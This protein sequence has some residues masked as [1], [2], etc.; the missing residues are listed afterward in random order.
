MRDL[1]LSAVIGALLLLVFKHPVIGAYLWAW[2]S[3]MN[4]H[5][6]TYG[7]AFNLP[8]ALA[9]AVVTLIALLYARERRPL[10]MNGI[11]IVQIVLLLWMSLTSLFAVADAASV[12]ERWIFVVKIQVML[13]ATWML[14]T[15]AKKLRVLIWVVTMSVAFFGFKG[16]VFTLLTGGGD[17]VWGPPGGMLEENN[18]LAVALIMLMPMM[19]FLRETEKTAWVRKAL[20]VTMVLCAFSILGSQS[21]GAL[22]AAVSMALFLGLKGKHAIRTSLLLV[23]FLV[24]A[25]AFMPETWSNRMDTV[26][27]YEQ[28]GSAMSRIWSWH[29]HWNAAVDRPLIGVGFNAANDVVFARYA[30]LDGPYAVFRG[31]VWVAHSI[32]FQMLGEHGFVGLGLFLLL[33]VLSWKK[34]GQLARTTIGDPE[35]SRWVPSLMR[36]VQVSLIGFAVGGAFLSLANHDLP[37]YF[38]GFVIATDGIVRR[39]LKAAASKPVMN[40]ALGASAQPGA[41]PKTLKTQ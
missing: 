36:M 31:R 38:I 13:M 28:D 1:V 3:L 35:L 6:L 15:D 34:A 23:V 37:Y 29:T 17:R 9:A 27:T 39:H 21:R 40:G 4:P 25:I 20:V 24:A 14:V 26:R 10:P 2:L 32:Y 33:G 18:A 7:F 30:P 5:K 8:F 22:L 19:F 11:V 16:G 12:L 41:Q